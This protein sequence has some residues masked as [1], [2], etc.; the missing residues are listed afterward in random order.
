MADYEQTSVSKNAKRIISSPL[1]LADFS[2]AVA[3]FA[4]AALPGLGKE[5]KSVSIRTPVLFADAAGDELCRIVDNLTRTDAEMLSGIASVVAAS[6]GM[7]LA[8]SGLVTALGGDS[9]VADTYA[10]YE[11]SS[12]TVTFSCNLNGDTLQVSFRRDGVY[13]L[14]YADDATAAALDAWCDEQPV[15]AQ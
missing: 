11:H 5:I 8:D 3:A 10:D 6:V 12:C 13:F 1:T 9:V 15:L 14:S 2:T 4:A 7:Y